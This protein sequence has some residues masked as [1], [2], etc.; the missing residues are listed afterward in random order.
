MMTVIRIASSVWTAPVIFASALGALGFALSV[1]NTI[2]QITTK[3]ADLLEARWE[4]QLARL[5]RMAFRADDR[6]GGYEATELF[7]YLSCQNMTGDATLEDFARGAE[8]YIQSERCA[9][10]T[11]EGLLSTFEAIASLYK[12]SPKKCLPHL[13]DAYFSEVRT[14]HVMHALLR[15]IQTRNTAVGIF[16]IESESLDRFIPGSLAENKGEQVEA[17]RKAFTKEA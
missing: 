15:A 2:A 5:A 17:L 7:L 11:P 12:R 4:R 14:V 10:E 16:L 8:N 13:L 9:P 3:N 6:L 1:Y